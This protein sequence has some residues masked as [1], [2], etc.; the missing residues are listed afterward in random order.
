M[1]FNQVSCGERL[2][3]D[4]VEQLYGDFEAALSEGGDIELD[5]EQLVFCD[6]AGLQLAIALQQKLATT[7]HQLRWRSPPAVLVETAQILG[8][9][10]ILN[11]NEQQSS[12][13]PIPN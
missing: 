5:A 1:A 4:R 8:L 6:S 11:L 10:Q 2:S 9:A 13:E 3:I 7:D 12:S